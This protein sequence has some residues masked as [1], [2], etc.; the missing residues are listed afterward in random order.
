M[1][2]LVFLIVCFCL[3][4]CEKESR[5]IQDGSYSGYFKYGSSQFW[6]SIGIDKNNFI[7]YA[8]G[9]VYSQKYPIYCLTKGTYKI[10][11]GII[12]FN[13]I[14]VA[15][16]PNGELSS[17]NQDFLLMGSYNIEELNDSTISFWRNLSLGKQEY[18]LKL[19]HSK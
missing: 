18:K 13:E 9:G 2:N 1:K 19:Y 4:S 8:S 6:E 11:D 14:Q 7:E 17:Y 3:L 10:H 16:P 15:Q 12:E 5:V